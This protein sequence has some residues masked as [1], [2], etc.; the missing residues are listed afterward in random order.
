MRRTS[1]LLMLGMVT[2]LLTAVGTSPAA[3]DTPPGPH[4]ETGLVMH[5]ADGDTLDVYQDGQDILDPETWTRVRVTGINSLEIG[6]CHDN[7]ARDRL[8]DLVLGEEI[9]LSSID[10]EA[11][12]LGRA[13]RH[14][15]FDVDED[16]TLDN[17]AEILIDEGLVWAFPHSD[18][19]TYNNLYIEG[20]RTAAAANLGIWDDEACATGPYQAA[21]LS[22]W[23]MWDADG[24]DEA[25]L[26]GEYVVIENGSGF[27]VNLNAWSVRDSA[28]DTYTFGVG[29]TLPAFGKV[30]L[31]VGSGTDDPGAGVY[32]W[33]LGEALFANDA[34]DG[35]YLLDPRL[36]PFPTEFDDWDSPGE[37]IRAHWDYPCLSSCGSPLDG[38]IVV[39]AN[40]DAAGSDATNPNGEWVHVENT[41][42]STIDLSGYILDT[43]PTRYVF[44][45]GT[46]V[47]SGAWLRIYSGSGTDS[48]TKKY[49]GN[50]SGILNN[51]SD[52]VAVQT[53]DGHTVDAFAWP[54]AGPCGPM[55]SVEITAVN[56]DAP[57]SDATN[58]NGE[59]VKI[60]NVGSPNVDLKGWQF[61]VGTSEFEQLN[62]LASRVLSNGES[63]TVYMGSGANSSNLMYWQEPSGILSNTGSVVKL[64]TPHRDV[65]S[66][67]AWGTV[68][69]PGD[70]DPAAGLVLNANY[71]AA[72]NDGTNPNGEW[73]N[74]RNDGG[75]SID[76]DGYVVRSWPYSVT[77]DTNSTINPGERM[78]IYIGSG[79]TNRLKKRFG[80]SGGVLNNGGDAVQLRNPDGDLV[81]SYAWPC[82]GTCGPVDSL[83]IET[84]NYDAVGND[85]TNPNGEWIIVR[86]T[87]GTAVDFRDWQVVS[88]PYQIN[89]HAS[90][91]IPP[92]GTMTIYIGSGIA[93]SDT[94]YWS[95]S[96]GILNNT[97]DIVKLLTP[98]R[99]LADCASWGSKLGDCPAPPV[100]ELVQMTANWDAVGADSTNPNGEWINIENTG[101]FD[102]DLDGFTVRSS[103]YSIV[104]DGDSTIEPGERMRVYIGS[105]SDSRLE[106]YMG[107]G[108]GILGNSGDTVELLQGASVVAD[109][110][111]PCGGSCG[112]L[113]DL[114]IDAVNYDAPGNDTTNPNGEWIVIRN[115]G[116]S[117]V[118]LRDWQ[119]LN[120]P[121][122]T[123][124][125]DSRVIAPG[126]TV[127]V[128]IGSGVDSAT[129]MYW[130]QASG[131][132]ANGGDVVKLLSPHRDEVDCFAW[133]TG[134]C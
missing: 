61:T 75:S 19:D 123:T 36:G 127:T 67:F 73:V 100:G 5:I 78:R 91:V 83:E 99:D 94:L 109:F 71:D 45:D 27:A 12:G 9:T 52:T 120:S 26:N 85:I 90:R 116:A 41:S 113:P 24:T 118:D 62:S 25:N 98:D 108:S 44:E 119:V 92:S 30:T 58:P 114:V 65:A 21:D 53:N 6:H 76:L 132:L 23:A 79:S 43:A 133:G 117:S 29:D 48:S 95:K 38:D 86:N 50:A 96:T 112:P 82:E 97:G 55:P 46:T 66:C 77:L 130:G 15:H 10:S 39:T 93:T 131:I 18:E 101:A 125:D 56:Y 4:T 69:C 129:E 37:D 122:A 11:E 1:L 63:L 72:G 2:G 81:L 28:L 34:G 16:E 87:G 104:L 84:V 134:S 7:P 88:P 80:R 31:Y 68:T 13:L 42:G 126:G 106:K 115:N 89:S 110:T 17:I 40:Y 124:S 22:M 14:V 54:C 20:A 47:A 49:Q 111:W 51:T 33:G 59:W 103:P 57:G 35:V 128:Y 105:G 3:A 74:I 70:D 64:K 102:A 121:A 107:Q 32:Y 8:A 60:E